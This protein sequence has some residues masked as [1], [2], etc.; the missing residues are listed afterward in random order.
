LDEN[1]AIEKYL[2]PLLEAYE[3]VFF[4]KNGRV[5]QTRKAEAIGIRL[6]A[7]KELFLLHG[8]YAP[9]DPKE[10]AQYGVQI[11]QVDIVRPPGYFRQFLNVPPAKPPLAVPKPPTNGKPP[12]GWDGHGDD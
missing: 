4:Q 2:K 10:A 9:R 11:V 6:S 1:T 7:L 5:T 8:S 12:G 3:T